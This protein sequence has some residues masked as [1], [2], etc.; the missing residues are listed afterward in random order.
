MLILIWYSTVYRLWRQ[1]NVI[2]QRPQYRLLGHM[3]RAT[4]HIRP[5][6]DFNPRKAEKTT[7]QSHS[8]EKFQWRS[9]RL[10]G[11][12]VDRDIWSAAPSL[13]HVLACCHL[14]GS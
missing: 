5:T 11:K 12:H 2:V 8:R 14:S 7:Q 4:L 13:Q 9:A 6:K 10:Q 1:K 3:A